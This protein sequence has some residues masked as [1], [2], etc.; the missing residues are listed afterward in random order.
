MEVLA[1]SPWPCGG[2]SLCLDWAEHLLFLP[3]VIRHHPSICL[4]LLA[5]SL[6]ISITPPSSCQRDLLEPWRTSVMFSSQAA[7]PSISTPACIYIFAVSRSLSVSPELSI[8]VDSLCVS[9]YL[10]HTAYEAP[11]HLVLLLDG[12]FEA[13][14]ASTGWRG[15]SVRDFREPVWRKTVRGNWQGIEEVMNPCNK[16]CVDSELIPPAQRGRDE[17]TDLSCG[18]ACW[19]NTTNRR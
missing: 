19:W 8:K 7:L 9:I 2:A 5:S 12:V 3:S 11:E 14:G 10:F 17:W 16:S 1:S 6:F 13:A 4:C 15:V 18:E